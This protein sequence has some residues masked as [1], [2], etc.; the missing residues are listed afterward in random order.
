MLASSLDRGLSS[1]NRLGTSLR[2]TGS[3]WTDC[4]KYLQMKCPVRFDLTLANRSLYFAQYSTFSVGDS[5]T[6]YTLTVG[7]YSGNLFDAMAYHNGLQFSTY[8]VDNDQ[9]CPGCRC[10]SAHEN[11]GFWYRSCLFAYITTPNTK[12]CAALY[13]CWDVN[14]V[15]VNL[16]C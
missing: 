13:T 10:T 12:W 1:D 9:W 15:E 11:A 4:T 8:D 6:N 2:Y 3:A 16:L 14:L 5:S 7:G